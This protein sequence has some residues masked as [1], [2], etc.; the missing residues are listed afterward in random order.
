M[1]IIGTLMVIAAVAIALFTGE[2][3]PVALGAVGVVFMGAGS[4]KRR[5]SAGAGRS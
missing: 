2:A 1:M 5:K 3:L 4:A